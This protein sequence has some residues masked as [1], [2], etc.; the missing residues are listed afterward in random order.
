M[1]LSHPSS[2]SI[3]Q[4]AQCALHSGPFLNGHVDARVKKL[5]FHAFE[6]HIV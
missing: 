3:L 4:T 6:L 2:K 1:S 5:S